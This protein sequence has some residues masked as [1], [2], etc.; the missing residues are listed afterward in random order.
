MEGNSAQQPAPLVRAPSLFFWNGHSYFCKILSFTTSKH[1]PNVRLLLEIIQ[2]QTLQLPPTPIITE[3]GTMPRTTR[4]AAKAQTDP[5]FEI[6]AAEDDPATVALPLTPKPEREPLGSITP[7]SFDGGEVEK[8]IEDDLAG[9]KPKGKAKKRSNKAKKA[10]KAK[11]N[12]TDASP[13]D[14]GEVSDVD[15][16]ANADP[17]VD[18]ELVDMEPRTARVAASGI[19]NGM[20]RFINCESA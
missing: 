5:V 15:E 3:E 17:G 10:I 1:I 18:D 6:S 19:G 16:N 13:M 2:N 20:Y 8:P 4:A 11:G 14:E 7:H 9:K 12:A